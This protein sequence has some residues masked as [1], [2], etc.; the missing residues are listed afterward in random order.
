MVQQTQP[1]TQPTQTAAQPAQ[2]L[3]PG[4]TGVSPQPIKKKSKWWIWVIIGIV[5]VLGASVGLYFWLF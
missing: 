1:G 3:S 4:T 2:R 5:I